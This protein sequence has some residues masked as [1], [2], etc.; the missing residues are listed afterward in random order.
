MT[1]YCPVNPTTEEHIIV[2]CQRHGPEQRIF[3]LAGD[4]WIEVADQSERPR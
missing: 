4:S 1:C 3:T 2:L